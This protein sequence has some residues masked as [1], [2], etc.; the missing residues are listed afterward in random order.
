MFLSVFLSFAKTTK[1]FLFIENSFSFFLKFIIIEFIN[2][3]I[4]SIM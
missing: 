4:V 1:C 2:I 3:Y